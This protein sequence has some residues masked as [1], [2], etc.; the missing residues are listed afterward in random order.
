MSQPKSWCPNKTI[1][2]SW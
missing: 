1:F 2:T